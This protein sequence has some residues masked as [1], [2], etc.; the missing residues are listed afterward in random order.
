MR[1]FT[2]F[3]LLTISVIAPAQTITPLMF[4]SVKSSKLERDNTPLLSADKVR[5]GYYESVELLEIDNT[6]VLWCEEGK[7][8]ERGFVEE[9]SR[10]SIMFK[11]SGLTYEWID[12]ARQE[13]ILL[14][15][16]CS[17]KQL[18]Y[19][20]PFVLRFNLSGSDILSIGQN[21]KVL[22]EVRNYDLNRLFV[23][24][25]EVAN[26]SY[27]EPKTALNKKVIKQHKPKLTK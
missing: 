10:H 26:N 4:A 1:I 24:G 3:I 8:N 9:G 13:G 14:K 2:Y 25:T 19:D 12:P 21:V 27:T 23:L 11:I 18:G 6:L 22:G 17:N 15:G 20:L 5:E 7:S 16:I